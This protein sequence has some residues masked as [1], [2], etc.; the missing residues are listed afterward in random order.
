M[1]SGKWPVCLQVCSHKP[2]ALEKL[3]GQGIFLPAPPPPPVEGGW[4]G[5][6]K[7]TPQKREGKELVRPSRREVLASKASAGRSDKWAGRL[8]PLTPPRRTPWPPGPGLPEPA[9]PQVPREASRGT[10]S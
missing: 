1:K 3:R 9:A 2:Q 7:K 6:D 5:R 4:G 10:R 8:L